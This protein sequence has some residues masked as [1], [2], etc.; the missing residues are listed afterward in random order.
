MKNALNIKGAARQRG[1]T[2]S[3][4]AKRLGMARSNM[5]AIAGGARGISM[6]KL[7]KISDILYCDICELSAKEENP[8]FKNKRIELALTAIE[9]GNYDGID[10]A[11]VGRLM[12]AHSAHY[13]NRTK[14]RV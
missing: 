10:K 11:W 12:Y 9:E 4:L 8:I 14:D 1:F 7:K 13:K 6:G 3:A 5:S 2:L